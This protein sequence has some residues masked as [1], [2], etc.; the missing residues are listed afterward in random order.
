MV[1]TLSDFF[2]DPPLNQYQCSAK[3][4]ISL[5]NVTFLVF[6]PLHLE[7]LTQ[8]PPP[9]KIILY[10]IRISGFAGFSMLT[11]TGDLIWLYTGY[12]TYMAQCGMCI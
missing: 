4:T 6:Y 3:I 10:K 7:L 9:K 2:L 12:K 11:T 8:I 5:N 1:G